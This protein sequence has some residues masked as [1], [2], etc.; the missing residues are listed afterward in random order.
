MQSR[1][2]YDCNILMSLVLSQIVNL[3]ASVITSL[4]KKQVR[5][6]CS[7]IGLHIV[8]FVCYCLEPA[9][10]THAMLFV[11]CPCI[12]LWSSGSHSIE[13]L[14]TQLKK[15]SFYRDTVDSEVTQRLEV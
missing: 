10:T 1:L 8:L 14:T 3:G 15:K 6:I 4:K 2:N 5:V 12:I 7:W 11:Y 9:R 13:M